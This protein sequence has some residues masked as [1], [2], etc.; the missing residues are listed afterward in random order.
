MIVAD[1]SILRKIVAVVAVI[2]AL[3][4]SAPAPAAAHAAL[5]RTEPAPGSALALFP[6][7]LRLTF[8]EAVDPTLSSAVLLSED[9]TAVTLGA[10]AT[11]P[12]DQ[13]VMTIA[14]A[15]STTP[16]PGIFTLVWGA[17]SAEDDH[18]SSGSFTFSVGTGVVP[19]QGAGTATGSAP[20]AIVGKWLE[21]IGSLLLTGLALFA[22]TT[23]STASMGKAKRIGPFGVLALIGLA[24]A[25]AS[26]RAR[27]VAI[28]GGGLIGPMDSRTIS[29]LLDS[30]YGHAWIVRVLCLL[31]VLALAVAVRRGD[32]RGAW[33]AIGS[34]GLL[35]ITTVA[36]SGHA[37][38][39]APSWAAMSVDFFHM[40]GA[41]VW[42]GGL[43]GL[44]L[45]VELRVGSNAYGRLLRSQGNRFGIAVVCIVVAGVVSAWW[46]IGGRRELTGSDYGQTLLIKVAI[47]AALIG[48]AFYNRYVLQGE[49]P[50]LEWTP[51]AAGLELVLA[52]VVLLL[53]SDLSQ[54]LPANQP[55]PVEI[56]ARAVEL[57]TSMSEGI[58]TVHLSGVLTGDPTDW[59]T[60]DIDPATDLQR[61]IVESRLTDSLSGVV[62]G[63]RFDADAVSGQIGRYQFPAGR[64]GVAGD[65]LLDIAVRREGVEDDV[66]SLPVDTS[67]LAS[68]SV[69]HVE[70]TWGG[71]RPTSHTA[72]A[73]GL[74]AIMLLVGL[75]GL[76]RITGLEPLAS[77]FLLAASLIISV[78]FLISAARSV[79]PR[80]SG[81]DVPNSLS[82][83]PAILVSAADL[84]RV[85][86]AACHGVDGA[87]VGSSNLA[88]LHGGSA[89]LTRSTTVEQSDGDLRY[90]I[91][92]GVPGSEM[93]AFSPALTEDEQWQLVLHIR[94]LQAAAL[95]T[96]QAEE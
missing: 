64:L 43:L 58:S 72:L 41:A 55:L 21:L 12:A 87:G 62:I 3:L 70:G 5:I 67:G 14:V 1:S 75:G 23:Q 42:L 56:A 59:I 57:D 61:V 82:P 78:G 9:G 25:L 52:M 17:F 93:P 79:V 11:D 15:D 96:A 91:A 18:A 40:T 51:F 50:R 73:L 6:E 24:G 66:V 49:H 63:D 2:V 47:V 36:V 20:A 26:F 8:T 86:C 35:A 37:G 33:P 90:W 94:E 44:L 27:E 28:S 31:G 13:H 77:G 4:L 74:A 84:Y 45:V 71:F 83:D 19:A 34:L 54:T 39:V 10:L 48:V 80:T 38:S 16:A 88:H 29:G 30:T 92:Q 32:H 53:S 68:H 85:N 60:V 46:Q 89:D 7:A 65:W 69:T 81:H 95:A 22:T 76:K